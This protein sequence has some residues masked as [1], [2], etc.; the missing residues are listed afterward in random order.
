VTNL[1]DAAAVLALLVA[2]TNLKVY[3]GSP[4]VDPTTGKLPA[5]PYVVL[6]SPPIPAATIDTLSGR[7]G[8]FEQIPQTTI[9]GD[10]PESVR[11]VSRRVRTALLDVVPVVADRVCLPIR[12]EGN[13][14]PIQPD[15]D[16]APPVL[17][18]AIRWLCSSTP[19]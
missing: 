6:W 16:V 18:S 5:R 15:T 7:S 17:W 8:W 19:A 10:T 12:M 1:D 4:P 2:D 11:I 14:L 13:P 3:D 9:V